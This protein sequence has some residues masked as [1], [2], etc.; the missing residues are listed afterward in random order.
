[1]NKR[2]R[3]EEKKLSL[4]IF[5]R[6]EILHFL[7]ENL[8][9]YLALPSHFDES[10]PGQPIK[11]ENF[12]EYRET[13]ELSLILLDRVHKKI[14]EEELKN[15]DVGEKEEARSEIQQDPGTHHG[16]GKG[17]LRT[18]SFDL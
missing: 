16:R 12:L 5:K 8:E 17:L 13:R 14:K 4:L 7:H 10:A 2:K 18:S 15:F 3:E 1:M 9:N 11:D 6:E